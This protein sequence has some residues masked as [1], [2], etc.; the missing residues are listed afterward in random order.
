[1]FIHAF[2]YPVYDEPVQFHFIVKLVS[3]AIG[4]ECW[5]H[6]INSFSA[7]AF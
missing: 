3:I 4:E 7:N 5:L 1:V 6:V 2:V